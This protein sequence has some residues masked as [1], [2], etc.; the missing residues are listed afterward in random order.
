[1]KEVRKTQLR[2]KAELRLQAVILKTVQLYSCA[3]SAWFCSL[4]MR[5][6]MI[7]RHQLVSTN[8]RVHVQ[9]LVG[10]LT[11]VCVWKAA[12][13]RLNA[14][15]EL[16]QNNNGDSPSGRMK[17]WRSRAQIST[18]GIKGESQVEEKSRRGNFKLHWSQRKITPSLNQFLFWLYF[19]L[20]STNTVWICRMCERRQNKQ[21]PGKI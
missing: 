21:T 3:P 10:A 7:F 11:W 15:T 4:E 2:G 14:T 6:Q 12:A 20:K 5:P 8:T 18:W 9:Y 16:V 17:K 19:L 1:M 13:A